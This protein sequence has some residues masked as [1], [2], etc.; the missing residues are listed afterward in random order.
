MVVV[1]VVSTTISCKLLHR[2]YL[3]LRLV[4][5]C[6][7]RKF[8]PDILDT[9]TH[10]KPKYRRTDG[11]TKKQ[12]D[13]YWLIYT[14]IH[15]SLHTTHSHKYK[16]RDRHRKISQTK[17]NVWLFYGTQ[18]NICT[19]GYMCVCVCVCLCVYECMWWTY[20]HTYI[21]WSF[22]LLFCVW[23]KWRKCLVK[24]VFGKPKNKSAEKKVIKQEQ[25]YLCCQIK[26]KC[27]HR[28]KNHSQPKCRPTLEKIKTQ[29]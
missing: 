6:I 15:N 11:W 3:L 5:F 16:Y 1:F 9:I 22:S 20:I 13:R 25:T 14:L 4:K 2:C 26:F 29:K 10:L 28:F 19:Y 23:W 8:F 12:T 7:F 21:S 17:R 27:N 24:I 18:I